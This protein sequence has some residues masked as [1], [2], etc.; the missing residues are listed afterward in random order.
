MQILIECGKSITITLKTIIIKG[1]L[2]QDSGKCDK[3][4]TS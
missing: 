1:A 3:Q 2:I 4:N